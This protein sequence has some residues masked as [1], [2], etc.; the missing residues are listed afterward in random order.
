MLMGNAPNLKI[1]S[2]GEFLETL[3]H[4]KVY[5]KGE[6][7]KELARQSIHGLSV[8]LIL[9]IIYLS[10]RQSIL[11]ASGVTLA[12]LISFWYF[13][14]RT[15]R[16]KKVKEFVHGFIKTFGLFEKDRIEKL[17]K[18]QEKF[19]LFEEKF[20]NKFL[21]KIS[22]RTGKIFLPIFYFFLGILFSLIFFGPQ[23]AV[24]SVIALTIGDS[25]S[26]IVGKQ[27]GRRKLF[28]NKDKTNVG[29]IAC[30]LATAAAVY[31][32]LYF[33][34]AGQILPN[35]FTLIILT[36]GVAAIVESLPFLNDNISIPL[37]VGFALWLAVNLAVII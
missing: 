23:I 6:K 31:V 17:A 1:G 16:K 32:F 28:Y 30:F 26:T 21:Y 3:K 11:L 36:A 20:I 24:F 10:E 14:L 35:L 19:E 12:A 9:P 27:F 8:L 15:K 29:T 2:S 7:I 34:P 33:F 5:K 4:T 13:D 25:M 18:N 37:V 22:E